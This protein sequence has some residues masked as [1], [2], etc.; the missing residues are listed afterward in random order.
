MKKKITAFL[1]AALLLTSS[2]GSTK[3]AADEC[4]KQKTEVRSNDKDPVMNLL[5]SA[6]IIF[7][8]QLLVTK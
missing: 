5:A 4:C 2:C 3:P 1:F 6:L 8:I 7:A